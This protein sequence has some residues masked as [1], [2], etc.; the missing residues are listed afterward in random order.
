MRVF[1]VEMETLE[2]VV[3]AA[4]KG[5]SRFVEG[6]KYIPASSIAGAIAR[7]VVLE[8]SRKSVGNCRDLASLNRTPD[9]ANCTENCLYRRL[10]IDRKVKITNGVLGE[11]DLSSPGISNLQTVCE[12]RLKH[13]KDSKMDFLLELLLE[14][15]VWLG[16]ANAGKI[17]NITEI[18]YKKTPSTY[19]GRDFAEI[20]TI[21]FTRVTIDENFRTSKEGQLYSFTAMGAKNRL[22]FMIHCDEEFKD[23][24]NGEM[25]IG[26]W[27]SRGMGLVKTKIIKEISQENYVRKR[28]EEINIGFQKIA[29]ILGEAGLDG[30]YG[31]YTY[32]TDGTKK[33]EIAL[34][35]LG[36]EI[37]FQAERIR[38]IIRYER[39]GTESLFVS[40]NTVSA[41]SAAVFKTKEPESISQN[42]ANL[43]LNIFDCP[44]FDWVFFNH[45]V[46]FEKSVLKG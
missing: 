35:K 34:K 36:L 26:A 18:G 24:L 10:W 42:L 4:K 45:P 11:W 2:P 41:G 12:P 44:W 33:I 21:Q 39:N 30:Y 14:R 25:K 28:S 1:L 29:E 23:H 7:K 3:I 17:K 19:N 6:L 22:R 32:L 13:S 37:A 46:H 15:M 43:E 16:K 8:N 9:C 38:K 40:V 5:K 31:T 20:K 27:K